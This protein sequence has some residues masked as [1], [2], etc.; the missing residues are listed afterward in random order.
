M[1]RFVGTKEGQVWIAGHVPELER[2]PPIPLAPPPFNPQ[3]P[4]QGTQCL[5]GGRAARE[6]KREASEIPEWIDRCYVIG[7]ASSTPQEA[8][9]REKEAGQRQGPPSQ[10]SSSQKPVRAEHRR[11][12]SLVC[13]WCHRRC[14]PLALGFSPGVNGCSTTLL[15][16][17]LHKSTRTVS[18]TTDSSQAMNEPSADHIAGEAGISRVSGQSC[19]RESLALDPLSLQALPSFTYSQGHPRKFHDLAY[20]CLGKSFPMSNQDLYC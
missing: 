1:K 20:S 18:S 6:R 5:P 8:R 7:A 14:P 15:P 16:S 11:R 2:P 4:R 12:S 3:L 17:F 9:S 10:R 19:V 13:F